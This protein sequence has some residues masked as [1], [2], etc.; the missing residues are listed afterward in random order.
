VFNVRTVASD[1]NLTAFQAQFESSV[2]R[3]EKG[4]GF[5]ADFTLTASDEMQSH[6]VPF[7]KFV[8]SWRGE[9]VGGAPSTAQLAKLT[10]IGIGADG[11]AGIFDVEMHS[12]SV[13]MA[14]PAPGP[15]PPGPA[16]GPP[17]GGTEL[18]DLSKKGAY[19]LFVVND[20]VMGG[21]STS[22]FGQHHGRAI[23]NGTVRIVPQLKAPGFCN[24]EIEASG[25]GKNFPD[26]TAQFSSTGGLIYRASSTGAMSSF[27]AAFGTSGEFN[28]GSYK[29]D[30]DIPQDGEMHNVFVPW[31]QFSNK[32]S[33]STGEPTVKCSADPKVCPT[34]DS[35]GKIGS[36]GI[37]AEGKAGDFHVEIESVTAVATA[38]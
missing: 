26:A 15:S 28:F 29:A 34:K 21:K 8:E 14:A 23:F 35:L 7:S 9:K 32:W 12:I 22:V 38:P 1:T 13:A 18:V 20:P 10:Q 4:G 3:S 30:F 36:V 37:W 19:R 25:F 27:K 6:F 33:P 16:P 17:A 24:A 5:Q 31:N 2:R 11:T